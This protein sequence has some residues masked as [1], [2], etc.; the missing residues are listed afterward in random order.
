MPG[1]AV[2]SKLLQV[3]SR[4]VFFNPQVTPHNELAKIKSLRA[5]LPCKTSDQNA[6]GL[7]YVAR[8]IH[9]RSWLWTDPGAS[10]IGSLPSQ[11]QRLH[12]RDIGHANGILVADLA[13]MTSLQ[14][15]ESRRLILQPT[16][17]MNNKKSLKL[18]L[19]M[20]RL[21]RATSIMLN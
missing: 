12:L 11:L 5:G 6:I 9:L 2:Y 4:P 20:I 3:D 7:P 21:T 8:V 15:W 17:S 19:Q 1:A 16:P 13:R 10:N 14:A 18:P